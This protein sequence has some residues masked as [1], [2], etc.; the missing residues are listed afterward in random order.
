M[1]IQT[2]IC[3]FQSGKI[4]TWQNFLHTS[5]V[6]NIKYG[7]RNALEKSCRIF[8][9]FTSLFFCGRGRA[10]GGPLRPNVKASSEGGGRGGGGVLSSAYPASSWLTFKVHYPQN[11]YPTYWSGEEK[12]QKTEGPLNILFQS[13]SFK[14]IKLLEL[15]SASLCNDLSRQLSMYRFVHPSRAEV[16]Q[17]ITIRCTAMKSI[18]VLITVLVAYSQAER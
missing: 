5:S 8:R 4:Y 12:N 10:V 15:T 7:L 2:E 3:A 11:E 9:A 16:S 1:P 17:F 13:S 6:A 18:F 14:D